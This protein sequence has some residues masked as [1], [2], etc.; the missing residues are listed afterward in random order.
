MRRAG[1]IGIAWELGTVRGTT[2]DDDGFP[3]VQ[4]DAYGDE[5]RVDAY[6]LHHP[7][8]FFSRP[9]D[10]EVDE[11]GQIRV[12]CSLFRGT[13]G[14]EQFAWLAGDPRSTPILPNCGKGE[15]IQYAAFGNTIK[16][17]VD[18]RISLWTS[19]DGTPEGQGVFW[20]IGPEGISWEGPYGRGRHDLSGYHVIDRSGARLDL[21][22]VAGL[23]APL[24]ALSSYAKISAAMVHIEGAVNVGT[25]N[26]AASEAGHVVLATVLARLAAACTSLGS[27]VV[28]TPAEI[29]AINAIGKFA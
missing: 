5:P 14:D 26:G 18:G 29:A 11:D 4:P 1:F 7:F 13:L 3:M 8:G 16:C 17:H 27:P 12:G 23:P 25:D 10:P 19:T 20:Q 9:L 24:S 6:E 21:G 28:I 15:S 22:G 2:F